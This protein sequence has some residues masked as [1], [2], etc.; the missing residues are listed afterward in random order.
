[1]T[2]CRHRVVTFLLA[3]CALSI[4]PGAQQSSVTFRSGTGIV[5]VPVWV[6]DGEKLVQGLTAAD[7]ELTDN[8]VAQD[9]AVIATASQPVDVT[10]VLDTSASLEGERLASLKSGIQAIG[11][12]LT[13]SDRVR[14]LSFATNVTEVFGFQNGGGPLPVERVTSG[15]LT[16]LYDALARG[17]DVGTAE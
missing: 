15:G 10:I 4:S 13:P 9:V 17:T 3:G 12:S 1:M 14:L 8:G 5:L 7:F 2:D 16:A 11:H 6:K